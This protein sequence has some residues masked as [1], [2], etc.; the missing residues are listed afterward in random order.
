LTFGFQTGILQDIRS[1]LDELNVDDLKIL[2][3]VGARIRQRIIK[4]VCRIDETKK[5]NLN[6]RNGYVT[7]H[8][9]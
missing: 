4:A 7:I 3:D 9:H 8:I 6:L 2:H 5:M 1:M